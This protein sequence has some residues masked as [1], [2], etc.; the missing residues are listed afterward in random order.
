MFI[1]L[2]YL[3]G[4]CGRAAVRARV[5]RLRRSGRAVF[6]I[7]PV[8]Y[9]LQLATMGILILA[10]NTSF[11]DFPRLASHPRPR[12]LHAAAA[13]PSAASGSPS[14]PGSSPWPSSR[15]SCWPPSAARVEALIPL[16][17]I[18]VFTSITLSQAGMVRHWLR[19]RT[20]GW[21]RSA[22]DQ[23]LRGGRRRARRRSSSPSRSSPSG[24]WLIVVIIPVLVAGDA[25][26][27]SPV[28]APT[29]R[30][31]TSDRRRSSGRRAAASAS[32]VPVP[33]VTRDVVQAVK[34]GRTMSDDVTARPRH[35]RRRARAR[36]PARASSAR[37]RASRSSSSSR[38]YRQLVRPLVR[39]LEESRRALR[40]RHRHRPAARVRAAP[41]VGAL[42]L[43]RERPPHPRARCSA[44]RTSSSPTSP[45]AGPPE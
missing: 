25:L 3:A 1:G 26:H 20:S 44:S 27:P 12:R 7:G 2:S 41:L 18:G 36:T 13:S 38:P 28:R 31:R 30:D 5:G 39:Y 35:R 9:V 23:R 33:D 37:C 24:A 15:S 40:R 43:Q 10:A 11:A 17:A 6:G 29:D 4:V 19:E 32:I 8:Y 21:R 14:T 42:P 34:F 22:V 45:S 16:Y